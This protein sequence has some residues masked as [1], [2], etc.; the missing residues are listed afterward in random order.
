MAVNKNA[1]IVP[2]HGTVF[3]ANQNTA[4]PA[5]GLSAFTLTAD[6][7]A[8]W[9]N[10]G[11]TS[12]DNTASFTKDGGDKTVLDT[13]LA[14]SVATIYASTQFGLTI[15]SLQIDQ[16]NLD[17]AFN[18]FFDT[19]GAYVI[20]GSNNGLGKALFLLMTDG[21]GQLGFY[22][23]TTTV[24]LG[25][26]PSIDPTKFFEVPVAASILAAPT[27]LI[28]AKGDGTPGIMKLYKSGLAASIPFL[29]SVSP[30]TA[31]TG[32][33]VTILGYGFTGVTGAAGVKF[34]STN[35]GAGNYTVV[36]DTQIVATVPAATAGAQNITV[37]NGT[38]TSA[39]L[40][41]THS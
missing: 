41:F 9:T 2:G 27:S 14:D 24:A 23:P 39:A 40:A 13:W 28:P 6:G 32:N 38:G 15:N 20:P 35:A 17:I 19:D 33:T 3:A 26:A 12:N 7:P 31:A 36:S 11:H 18:G 8:G 5:G 37:T 4:M 29:S 22:I 21:T 34:G 16:P 25:D 30:S 1:L 10:L